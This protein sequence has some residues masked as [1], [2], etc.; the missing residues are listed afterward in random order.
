MTMY[1]MYG[2]VIKAAERAAVYGYTYQYSRR[3]RREG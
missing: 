1:G 3:K 2:C